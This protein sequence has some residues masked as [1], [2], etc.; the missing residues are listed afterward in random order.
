MA[1]VFADV[2]LLL[3]PWGFLKVQMRG[4]SNFF[5]SQ[6]CG[7]HLERVWSLGQLSYTVQRELDQSLHLSW[8][9]KN[10]FLP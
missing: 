5:E 9:K 4:A 2:S 3:V 1:C 6:L 8:R 7:A 10:M